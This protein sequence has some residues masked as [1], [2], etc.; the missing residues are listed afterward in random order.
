MRDDNFKNTPDQNLSSTPGLTRVGIILCL[1]LV[2]SSQLPPDQ[3]TLGASAL[4]QISAFAAATLAAITQEKAFE[5]RFSRWDEAV[6]FFLLGHLVLLLP[7][8]AA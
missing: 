2:L 8:G 5:L 1:V 6:F 3:V 4:L 7:G